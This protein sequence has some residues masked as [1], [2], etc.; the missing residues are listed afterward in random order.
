MIMDLTFGEK[1]RLLREDA[2]LT[3]TD[4]G[5]LINMT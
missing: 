1:I 5:K 3:Q 2:G 4:L